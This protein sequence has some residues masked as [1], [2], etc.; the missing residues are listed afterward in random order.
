MKSPSETTSAPTARPAMS[1]MAR[2]RGGSTNSGMRRALS[3][4]VVCATQDINIEQSAHICL[5]KERIC[6]SRAASTPWMLESSARSTGTR[7]HLS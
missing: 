3:P 7:E 2:C 1:S 4:R 6:P 5:T